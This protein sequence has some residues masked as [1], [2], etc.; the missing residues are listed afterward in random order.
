MQRTHAAAAAAPPAHHPQDARDFGVDGYTLRLQR[1]DRNIKLFI[2]ITLY[3]ENYDELR[4]TL[5]GVCDVS[6]RS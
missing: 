5:M 3:N 6:R 4:K 2:C 1:M